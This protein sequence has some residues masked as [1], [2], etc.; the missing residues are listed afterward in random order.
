MEWWKR[1][2]QTD[3]K[4]KHEIEARS[5]I[6][7]WV[8]ETVSQG[9]QSLEQGVLAYCT[10]DKHASTGNNIQNYSGLDITEGSKGV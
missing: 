10:P 6:L 1:W 2:S 8:I 5:I 7:L 3:N 9:S 4:M